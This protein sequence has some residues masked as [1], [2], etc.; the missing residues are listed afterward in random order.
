MTDEVEQIDSGNP[1]ELNETEQVNA[2]QL[3]DE[4]RMKVCAGDEV[5]DEEVGR[6]IAVFRKARTT[7]DLT[8]KKQTKKADK[9]KRSL[10]EILSATIPAQE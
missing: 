5:S 9:P 10:A 7:I 4:L 6:V 2:S 8:K 1:T 3:V